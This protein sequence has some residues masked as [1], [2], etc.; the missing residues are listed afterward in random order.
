MSGKADEL[1]WDTADTRTQACDIA[2]ASATTDQVVLNFGTRIADDLQAQAFGARLLRQ[3]ALRP[4]SAK[5]LR[6]MLA[7]VV[8]EKGGTP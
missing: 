1:N 7:S 6:D 4:A 3:I 2:T 5:H 8:A